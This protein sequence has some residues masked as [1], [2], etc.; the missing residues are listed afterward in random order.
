[1][2]SEDSDPP[3]RHDPGLND[4]MAQVLENSRDTLREVRRFGDRVTSLGDR[5]TSLESEI[6]HSVPT[7]SS[8]AQ[9]ATWQ[10]GA[11]VKLQQLERDY[12]AFDRRM[13]AVE[14]AG[15]KIWGIGIA[16]GAVAGVLSE[17]LMSVLRH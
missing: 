15:A 10:A 6:K 7:A 5:L 4:L 17:L 11:E 16:L 13:Q 14:K 12:E 8:V 3:R 9:I 1:M 2:S